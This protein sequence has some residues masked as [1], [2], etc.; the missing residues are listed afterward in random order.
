MRRS[1]LFVGAAG[2]IFGVWSMTAEAQP[3]SAPSSPP[4]P[5]PPDQS[6]QSAPQPQPTPNDGV[7][8][9]P[10]AYGH[11]NLTHAVEAPLHTL[12]ITRQ[13]IPAV[14][15]LAMA[16][17]TN[18]LTIDD[19]AMM[20]GR[21]VKVAAASVEDLNLL[22]TRLARMDDSIE[23]I[24]DEDEDQ[25]ERE[26]SVDEADADAVADPGEVPGTG[27]NTP[28]EFVSTCCHVT[29]KPV[30]LSPPLSRG[31]D[32]ETSMA[33]APSGVAV[34]LTKAPGTYAA[35][36]VPEPVAAVDEPAALSALS[37]TV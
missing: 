22:L 25:R 10:G 15:L 2:L 30:R 34:T 14:L 24:V 12:N 6:D 35:E 8:Q 13:K 9:T 4:P 33:P 23:D 20:T 7:L 26:V 17:P 21:R 11:S 19:V 27:T 36:G 5:P 32:H 18:V 29:L 28:L 1:S 31:G 37:E 3:Y 16:D